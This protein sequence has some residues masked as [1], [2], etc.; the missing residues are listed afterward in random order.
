MSTTDADTTRGRVA[1]GTELV[2]GA[3]HGVWPRLRGLLWTWIV[4]AISLWVAFEIV[5]GIDYSGFGS[6]VGL[7]LVVGIVGLVI[8]PLLNRLALAV[9]WVGIFFLAV[10]AQAVVLWIAI[11]IARDVSYTSLWSVF[12]AAWVASLVATA[13]GFFDSV[14]EDEV[15]LAHVVRTSLRRRGAGRDHRRAGAGHHPDGRRPAAAAALRGDE[16]QGADDQ[17]VGEGGHAHDQRVDR[18]GAV[19][20]ADQPGRD[21]AR[22][23]RGHARVPL[24]REGVRA[25]DRRQP[26][27]GR[28]A[29]REPDLRRPRVAR[30]R[31]GERQQPVQR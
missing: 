8:R 11:A 27:A 19:D 7:A 9:G 28:R 26:P 17:Q 16:R 21:P 10:F 3:H 1:D 15:F 5:P 12:G 18:A 6:I 2:S 30:R 23:H 24:V 13:V 22:L 31:R 4:T 25:A 14:D 20:H 29:H